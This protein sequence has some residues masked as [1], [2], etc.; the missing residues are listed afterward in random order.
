MPKE[1]YLQ[2]EHPGNSAASQ[3]SRSWQQSPGSGAAHWHNSSQL[4][5]GLGGMLWPT[6]S[7]RNMKFTCLYG[8]NALFAEYVE[9]GDV[10]RHLNPSFLPGKREKHITVPLSLPLILFISALE[11]L[12]CRKKTCICGKCWVHIWG[13]HGGMCHSVMVLSFSITLFPYLLPRLW[14]KS[15]DTRK[16]NEWTLDLTTTTTTKNY[17]NLLKWKVLWKTIKRMIQKSTEFLNIPECILAWAPS[18]QIK[19]GVLTSSVRIKYA[20]F[21]SS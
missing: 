20:L 10:A 1:G 19:L 4:V 15:R 7:G 16:G 2:G 18:D 17:Q 13:Q 3:S 9:V 6:K 5:F 21:H 14:H 11:P 8:L 12:S